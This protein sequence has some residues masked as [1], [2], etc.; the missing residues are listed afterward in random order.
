ME[1]EEAV[2]ATTGQMSQQKVESRKRKRLD[3]DEDK[4]SD[5]TGPKKKVRCLQVCIIW[6]VSRF[7]CADKKMEEQAESIG[8]L[9]KRSCF[10][11]R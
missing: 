5:G 3:V 7:E 2:D 1:L 10:Q 4:C 6:K 11:V 8:V 9:C